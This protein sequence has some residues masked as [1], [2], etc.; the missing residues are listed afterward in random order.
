MMFFLKIKNKEMKG[1][2][3]KKKRS[4][5]LNNCGFFHYSDGWVDRI[6]PT[7]NKKMK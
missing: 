5:N 3:K 7:L 6:K 4:L 2:R 1:Y